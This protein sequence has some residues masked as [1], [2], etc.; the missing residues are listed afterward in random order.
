MTILIRCIFL[1]VVLAIS[2][3]SAEEFAK[4]WTGNSAPVKKLTALNS[5][6]TEAYQNEDIPRL[7]K[8][9]TDDHI[10][11]NVFGSVMNKET[12]LRDIES[13]ILVF[14]SYT[15]PELHWFIEGDMAV[16]TGLIEAKAIRSGKP[17]P[18]TR[19]RFTRIFVRREGQWKVLL[20]QNTMAPQK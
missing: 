6:L 9:L 13:G 4:T 2:F 19:F 18:A 15:T 7:R 12:F 3:A 1:L 8:L 16:A 17:V 10:H 11:N 20:F 5:Q 14:E